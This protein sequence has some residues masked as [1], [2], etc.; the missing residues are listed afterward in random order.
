MLLALFGDNLLQLLLEALKE[1]IRNGIYEL[2]GVVKSKRVERDITPVLSYYM[3]RVKT[4]KDFEN[5]VFGLETILNAIL[6]VPKDKAWLYETLRQATG[7][8]QAAIE[9]MVKEV[10]L[11][12]HNEAISVDEL[13]KLREFPINMSITNNDKVLNSLTDEQRASIQAIAMTSQYTIV[14]GQM[15]IMIRDEFEGYLDRIESAVNIA[16]FGASQSGDVIGSR[17]G[18]L[19]RDAIRATLI[20]D[21]LEDISPLQGGLLKNLAAKAKDLYNKVKDTPLVQ[22]LKAKAIDI[23]NSAVV[24]AAN[25]Y[26]PGSGVVADKLFDSIVRKDDNDKNDDNPPPEANGV[27]PS[28]SAT[29]TDSNGVE[30]PR[31]STINFFDDAGDM[32]EVFVPPDPALVRALLVSPSLGVTNKLPYNAVVAASLYGAQHPEQVN[33]DED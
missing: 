15:R 25:A 29:I 11:P 4:E 21:I 20:N 16:G 18:I 33:P 5:F 8:K 13:K 32:D 24:A 12:E 3:L 19:T 26:I 2:I 31:S 7:M 27:I 28:R 17:D 22:T 10:R 6:H 23:V 1:K 30:L 14:L 9:A